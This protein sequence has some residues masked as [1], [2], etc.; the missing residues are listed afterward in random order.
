[1]FRGD[2]VG[3]I[4]PNGAGKSTLL[5]ILLGDLQPTSGKVRLGTNISVGYFD[6]LRSQL[7]DT[8][9]ARENVSD[10]TDHLII[11]GQKKHVM[12]FLQDFLFSPDRAHTLAGFLSGGER[13]RLLLAKMMSKPSNVLVLDEPTNDLDAETLE[14]LEDVLPAFGGTV[15]LVSHDRAFLNN[16]ATS[17]IVF[18][19]DGRLGEYDGGYDDWI[20]V[21][22][23]RLEAAQRQTEKP[24]GKS[25]AV[26][27]SGG[28]AS[29]SSAAVVPAAPAAAAPK[30]RLSFKE[31]RELEDLPERIAGLE[32]RQK[33]LNVEMAAPG[34]FQSGGTRIAAVTT[35]LAKVSDELLH[36]YERW[37]LL[38]GGM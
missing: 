36:C 26:S 29:G 8:K 16:V 10:G 9:T 11:N 3:I 22:D 33:E 14:L 6:Q 23:Q 12:G 37:E 31:Q 34:F 38:E 5:R 25:A 7:D 32:Q 35:E 19:G 24:A 18:E 28:A 30:R 1:V 21:R 2:K 20:R 17:L 15:F 13:N 4:G 27:V